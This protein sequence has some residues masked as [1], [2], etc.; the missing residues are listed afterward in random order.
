MKRIATALMLICVSASAAD[1][2]KF[3][4][5]LVAPPTCTISNGNTIEVD[6]SKVFIDRID[7]KNFMQDVPYTITCSSS[8]RDSSLEMTLTLTGAATDYNS[9][10]IETDVPGLGIELQQDGKPFTLGST[11]T[12][13][14]SARPT[15]KAVPVKKSGAVL[16]ESAFSAWATLQVDYQ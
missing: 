4:G 13:A 15:L 2:L 1:N 11:I 9:A 7:G 3:H 12:I 16:S 8:T 5:T 6:F 14:E 10:A